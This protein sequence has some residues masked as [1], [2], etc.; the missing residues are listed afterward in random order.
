M[1]ESRLLTNLW[2]FMVCCK[3][4]FT[5][6][7]YRLNVNILSLKYA[8]ILLFPAVQATR[9][10]S[11]YQLMCCISLYDSNY[12]ITITYLR[13]YGADPFLRSRQLCSYSRI[14]QQFTEPDVHYSVHK[15][16]PPIPIMSEINS[17]HTIPSCLSKIIHH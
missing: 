11:A 6:Y 9:R 17:V 8:K 4:S 16:P 7:Q 14:S 2:T 15:S 10:T 13:T 5:F 1:W 12:S 3:D